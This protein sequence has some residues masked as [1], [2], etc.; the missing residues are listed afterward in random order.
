MGSGVGSMTITI[1]GEG[2]FSKGVNGYNATDAITAPAIAISS[3]INFRRTNPVS[4]R[5]VGVDRWLA[6]GW[7]EYPTPG[8]RPIAVAVPMSMVV[9]VID[10]P[11]ASPL[12]GAAEH[13]HG[14]INWRGQPIVVTDPARWIGLQ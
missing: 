3:P 10:A 1:L 8:S 9:E 12:P 13:I 4:E 11:P 14:L 6:I 5:S 2:S 7:Q